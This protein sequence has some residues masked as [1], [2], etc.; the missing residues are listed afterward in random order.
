VLGYIFEKYINQKEFGA[1]YTR[2]EITEYLCEQT[3]HQLVLDRANAGFDEAQKLHAQDPKSYPAPRRFTALDD[4]LFHA[5][6]PLCGRLLH[7]VLPR[8][9]LL[10]PACGSGAFLVAAQ[11]TLLNLYT[12]LLGRCE[13]LTHRPVIEWIEREK[14]GHQAPVAYWLKKKIVTENLYGVDLMEEAVEIAK[15]RLFLSLVASAEKRDQLEPLPNIEFN[16][17]AGNSL[18]GLLHVDAA[19]FDQGSGASGSAGQQRLEFQQ[20]TGAGELAMTFTS[21]T[22][23]TL[24]EKIGSYLA[25]K[26]A[27]RYAAILEDKNRSIALYK[28]HGAAGGEIEGLAQDERLLN[29]RAHIENLRRESYEQLNKLL[30]D[31]FQALG[32]Q[33]QQ[34][35][36]DTEKKKEG[37]PEKRPLRL[38][39]IRALQPFHWAYEFD[40]ILIGRGG[41]DAIITNPPWE[42]VE[43]EAKKFFA[44]HSDLVTKNKM[45]LK[46]FEKEQARLLK[47]PGVMDAWLAYHSRFD[48]VRAYFRS[49]PQFA[50]QVPVI[51]GKKQGKDVNL[52]KLFLEQCIHLLHP[53]ARCGIVIPSGIYTDLG[54]MR[55]RQ[56]LFRETRLTGLFCFE[57]RKEIFEGVHRS[58]KFV[59]LTFE[60]GGGTDEFPATYMRHDPAELAS[61]PE[62]AALHVS[63]HLVRKLSPDSLSLMEF[64]SE[65]EV[66]TA[67][68]LFRFPLLSESIEGRWNFKIHREFNLTD[69]IAL[70]YEEP[71]KNR[72]PLLTGKMFHQFTLTGEG[73]GY[74]LDEKAGRKA[75]AGGEASQSVTMDYQRYRWVYRRIARNTDS[76]TLI[77]TVAPRNMFTEVNSPVL[78]L[79]ESGA[80]TAEQL[81]LCAV[82]NSFALDWYLRLKVTTT[83]NFFY[84]YQLPIPRLSAGD[85]AFGPLVER[86]ARLVGTSAEFDDLLREIFGPKATHRTHGAR[87]PASRVRL[88]AELDALVAQLYALTEPEFTHILKTFPLVDESVRSQTLNTYRDLLHLGRL[89]GSRE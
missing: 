40:D 56:M 27:S 59:V 58:F 69:D 49:S 52:Y 55:L 66:K 50:N 8:L 67:E 76:R 44:E 13:A 63:V 79:T 10:D 83:L 32:I 82:A 42:S 7:D 30:L 68:K 64:R 11:K 36:W 74:W 33:Y 19:A 48:H 38:D 1:Y 16:L 71:G 87:D 81:F 41:F 61:F 72:L 12:A 77:S 39:D 21:K 85:T 4:L 14:K 65:A 31:E 17:L 51:D 28:R 57:N 22:A 37:K 88:R 86:A 53:K 45:T 9:S 70:F 29:L 43:P 15:L 60:K 84:I 75:L 2:P 89:P 35:T 18:I 25:A 20:R 47:H 62:S 5:D 80:S 73:S 54:A 23:P 78:D 34:A 6:G 46:D 24:R 3:I 26:R